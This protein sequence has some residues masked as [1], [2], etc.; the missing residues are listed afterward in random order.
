MNKSASALN[1]TP[2]RLN[3]TTGSVNVRGG[4]G[5]PLRGAYCT[6]LEWAERVGPFKLDPF[7][8]ERSHIDAEHECM[9]ENGG[10]GFGGGRSGVGAYKVGGRWPLY[11]VATEETRV[12]FQPDYAYVL[13]ALDHYQHTRF[14]ALLRFDPRTTWWKRI[15]RL[16]ELVCL[17]PEIQFEPPPGVK[18]VGKGTNSFP[19]ALF[20]KCADDVTDAVLRH[21]FAWRTKR[22][23]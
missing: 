13:K 4:S 15:Y 7:T 12:W 14:T 8:N 11:S 10:D 17:I 20:Y 6:P 1:K 9:L 18:V 16:S 3:K 19:H 5:D 2:R 23:G 22:N 21:T